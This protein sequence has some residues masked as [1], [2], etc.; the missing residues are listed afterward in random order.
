MDWE[1]AMKIPIGVV[2]AGTG[3]GMAKSLLHSASKTYSVPNAVFAIIRGLD[4]FPLHIKH[5][6]DDNL[7]ISDGQF[8]GTIKLSR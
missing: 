4:L 5:I 6:L 3:N 7:L 2:P 8:Y 1:E